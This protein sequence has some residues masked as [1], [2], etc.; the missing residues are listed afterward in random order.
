MHKRPML[1]ALPALPALLAL[2]VVVGGRAEARTWT[3]TLGRTFEAE[4]VRL[5]GAN[6]IFALANGR[7]FATPLAD[8]SAGD[9]AALR[10]G[11]SAVP[12][13]AVNVGGAW[14][15]EIRLAGPVAC[16]VVAEDAK[17]RRYVYESPSYR[18]TCD[19]RVT[20]DALRNFSVMFEATRKYALG[21]PLGLGGGRERQGKLD[22]LLYGSL[23]SYHEAGGPVGS[24]GCSVGS[25]VL[26]PMASL[27]LIEGGTGFSLNSKRH[28]SVLV[29]E[30]VHQLTPTAYMA[31]GARG[32]FSEG[33]AESL[34][35]TPYNW[36]YYQPDIHGTVVK[37][38][39]TT[40]GGDGP[41]GRALGLTLV[42]PPL[43]D[44]FLM[45]YSQYCGANANFNYGLG[46]LVT[47]YFLHQEGGGKMFRLTQFLKG[48]QAGQQ[49]EA[50]LRP[51][52]GG[53]TYQK[54]AGEIT[55]S[56]AR[57]GVQIRFGE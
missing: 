13:A 40:Q 33:L 35:I 4:L 38:Y 34:A 48:L 3:T 28:N 46:L 27:G 21:V 12:A 15:R 20:D 57:M 19:A 22:I 1:P 41:A 51:L 30:L 11:A 10:G 23:R 50:A 8:L 52:L 44:F 37:T 9:Q 49:G 7:T 43:K 31:P 14:P 6:A 54:L 36:G 5:D 17:T 55:A 25:G 26:V 29:H 53:G 2:L 16:K 42:A 39:V 47:D 45:P 56:W 32:W 18:F 24:A